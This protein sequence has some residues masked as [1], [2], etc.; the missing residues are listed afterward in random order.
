[1]NKVNEQN[2]AGQYIIPA[3]MWARLGA[4]VREELVAASREDDAV[5]CVR[6]VL[7]SLELDTWQAK[8]MVAYIR[9][10]VA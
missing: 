1:M 2:Q 6:L 4:K 5:L 7:A 8:N 9:N 10:C 3:S